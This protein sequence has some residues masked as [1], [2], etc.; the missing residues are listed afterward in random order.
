MPIKGN[1]Q[2]KAVPPLTKAEISEALT[3]QVNFIKEH[4]DFEAEGMVTLL[5]NCKGELV[6]CAIDNKTQSQELDSEVVAVFA[7]LKN[8]KPAT[9]YNKAVDSVVHFRFQVKDG[10]INLK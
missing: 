10:K 2:E 9:W 5:V 3:S 4:P 6:R 8:W 1:G 7:T